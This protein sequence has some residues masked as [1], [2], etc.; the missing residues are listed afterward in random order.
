MDSSRT[1]LVVFIPESLTF[2]VLTDQQF[3][4]FPVINYLPADFTY[5]I[6]VPVRPVYIRRL[7]PRVGNK[8]VT[9]S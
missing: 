1:S 2:A 6:T 4:A 9:G 3:P 5:R 7:Y 8:Q